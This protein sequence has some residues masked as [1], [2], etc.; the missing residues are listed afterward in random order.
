LIDKVS[1]KNIA[2]PS[3]C[4]GVSET[5]AIAV[6]VIKVNRPTTTR[7]T[8]NHLLV[9]DISHSP[10]LIQNHELW[11]FLDGHMKISAF[12]TSFLFSGYYM[13]T[14]QSPWLGRVLTMMGKVPDVFS[15]VCDDEGRNETPYK[16]GE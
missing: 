12:A 16:P 5:S 7:K 8:E 13:G 11:I 3:S 1:S 10:I 14:T 9:L 6:A 15:M 4:S 2:L